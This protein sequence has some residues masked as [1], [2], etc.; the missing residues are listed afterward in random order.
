M[1]S[2]AGM[3]L[4]LNSGVMA[5]DNPF[6][7]KW[8]L[9]MAKSDF[10]GEMI[11]YQALKPNLVRYTGAGETYTFTTDGHP[12]PGLFGR[13]VSVK[14]TDTNT[15]LRTTEFKGKIL[16]E[17][18]VALSPDGNT[19]TETSRGTWPDGSAFEKTEV[20]N[21]VGEGFGMVGAM[22]GT[23]RSKSA[24]ESPGNAC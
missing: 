20:Y 1:L 16:S 10:T 18:T 24:T 17:T 11:R 9:D 19:L 4:L 8:K 14:Q 23:W 22:M 13:M 21:R 2:T 12:H 3:L 7:S 6:T 5:A 15:W